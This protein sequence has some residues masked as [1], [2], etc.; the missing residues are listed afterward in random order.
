[1]QFCLL[2]IFIYLSTI[3]Y[4]RIFRRKSDGH[5]LYDYVGKRYCPATYGIKANLDLVKEKK[6]PEKPILKKS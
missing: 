3:I 6:L 1:M 4:V 2:Y 5:L